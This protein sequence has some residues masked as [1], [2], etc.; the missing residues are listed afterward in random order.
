[1][2]NLLPLLAFLSSPS[3]QR[4]TRPFG[5]SLLSPVSRVSSPRKLQSS[6]KGGS[7]IPDAPRVSPV[8]RA[9]PRKSQSRKKGG[10]S[11]LDAPRM[12]RMGS[13]KGQVIIGSSSRKASKTKRDAQQRSH[14]NSKPHSDSKKKRNEP[15]LQYYSCSVTELET[16]YEDSTIATHN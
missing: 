11:S 1:M 5:N 4:K 6:R 12:A 13:S 15:N 7:V 16:V 8:G 2:S 9:S 14:S 10:S 3:Q